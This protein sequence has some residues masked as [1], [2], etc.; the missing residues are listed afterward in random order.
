MLTFHYVNGAEMENMAR[1]VCA[2]HG[3]LFGTDIVRPRYS[4]MR[5]QRFRDEAAPGKEIEGGRIRG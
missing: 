1:M 5:L 2:V 4:E 3:G